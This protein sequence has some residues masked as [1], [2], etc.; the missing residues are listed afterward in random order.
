MTSMRIDEELLNKAKKYGINVSAFLEIKL[1]EYLALIER[2]RTDSLSSPPIQEPLTIDDAEGGIRTLAMNKH[3]QLSRRVNRRE[4][5]D[6]LSFKKIQG[7]CDRWICEI[8]RG[9]LVY[10]NYI[11]YNVSQS[12]TLAFLKYKKEGYAVST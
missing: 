2:K 6:Y 7:N 4:L 1:R 11:D 10:L 3:H 9:L 8:R 5:E 12:K